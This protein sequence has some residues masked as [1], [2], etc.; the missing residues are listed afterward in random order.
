[1]KS[2]SFGGVTFFVYEDHYIGYKRLMS[3]TQ[4]EEE[5]GGIEYA[6]KY[7]RKCDCPWEFE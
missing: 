7:E 5:N 6:E 1:M 3:Y 4:Y 2:F